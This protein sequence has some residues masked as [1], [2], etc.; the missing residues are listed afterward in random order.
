MTVKEIIESLKKYPE[1]LEVFTKKI[2]ICGNIGWS[3]SV[4]EDKYSLF[5][6]EHSCVIISDQC[7]DDDEE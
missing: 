1:D 6:K 5:G 7:D 4:R 3:F 2:D